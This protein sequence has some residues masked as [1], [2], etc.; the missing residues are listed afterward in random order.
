MCAPKFQPSHDHHVSDPGCWSGCPY[1]NVQGGRQADRTSWSRDPHAIH[2]TAMTAMTS[3]TSVFL[4]HTH[5]AS[6]RHR[7]CAQIECLRPSNY[8][9]NAIRRPR[10]N[11]FKNPSWSWFLLCRHQHKQT[12]FQPTSPSSWW[13]SMNPTF[14]EPDYQASQYCGSSRIV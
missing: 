9:S 1:V 11:T 3:Q 8:C 12:P 6:Y 2:S 7:A 4:A 13:A 10:S 14:H 5:G